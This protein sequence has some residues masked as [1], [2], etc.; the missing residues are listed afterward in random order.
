MVS[1]VNG[2]VGAV[3]EALRVLL[4]AFKRVAEA[5]CE[6]DVL[7]KLDVPN[8]AGGAVGAVP[9]KLVVVVGAE[10]AMDVVRL[11]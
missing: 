2:T 10:A 7:N 5:V 4:A 1:G 6:F 11:G 3:D 9:N 8:V